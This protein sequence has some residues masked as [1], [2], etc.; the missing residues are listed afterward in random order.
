MPKSKSSKIDRVSIT[1]VELNVLMAAKPLRVWKA[2]I[3]QTGAW[4]PRG[5][6]TDER[7][8]TMKFEPK[9]GG[10][11]YEDWGKG[12]GRTWFR[13]ETFDPPRML[14]MSGTLF[15]SF[16]GPGITTV[17]IEVEAAGKGTLFKLS[18]AMFGRVDRG[19]KRSF[20]EG[21]NELFAKALKSF[22]ER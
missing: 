10:L 9:L 4:W 1:R 16:G 11:L 5:F 18:D 14:E 19:T 8:V 7:A 13:I 22:V 3:N 2:L 6:F 12:R 20:E 15:S 17:R 21:W